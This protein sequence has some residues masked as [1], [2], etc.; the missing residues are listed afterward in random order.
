MA[1]RSEHSRDELKNLAVQAGIQLIEEKGFSGFSARAVAT[2][3]GYTVGTIYHLF[4]TLDE[5]ILHIN[6]TTLDLWYASME[7]ALTGT[8]EETTVHI[9]AKAYLSFAH[10]HYARWSALFEHRMAEDKPLPEW[11]LPKMTRFFAL[12]DHELLPHL[13]NNHA[14]TR[15]AGKAL[16]A[17]IHGI[18]VLALSGKLDLVKA[19]SPESLVMMLVDATLAGLKHSP[20]QH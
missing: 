2:K 10:Q 3:M 4:G 17:G 11:Y 13:N 12:L 16:W 1:R 8:K 7:H 6:A 19:E 15:T 14:Q 20:I 9:L 18:C 5:F